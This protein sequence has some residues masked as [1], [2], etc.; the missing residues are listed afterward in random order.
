MYITAQ[1][2]VLKIQNVQ[3]LMM[4]QSNVVEK[5]KRNLGRKKI[6]V[7]KKAFI[8]LKKEMYQIQLIMNASLLLIIMDLLALF[9]INALAKKE[10]K[11][12]VLI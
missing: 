1:R 10:Q 7:L 5:P 3:L 8:K 11:H 6:Y 12:V 4:H 2:H 9:L